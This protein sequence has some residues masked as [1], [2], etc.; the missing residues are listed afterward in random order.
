MTERIIVE[1]SLPGIVPL[2][3]EQVA[4]PDYIQHSSGCDTGCDAGCDTGCDT[5]GCHEG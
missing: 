3:S 2:I 4:R 5:G 1:A